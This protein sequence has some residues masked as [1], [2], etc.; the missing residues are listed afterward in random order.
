M[1]SVSTNEAQ[2]LKTELEQRGIIVEAEKWDGHKHIDLV[3]HRARLNI[4]VDGN[5][6]YENQ[7]Q[8]IADLKRAHYSSR[9]GY[10]TFHIPN[11]FIRNDEH[12]KRVADALAAAVKIRAHDLGHRLPYSHYARN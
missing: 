3:I 4:E 6:H 10:D 8:I 5:H 9:G 12:L 11:E 1:V 2:A 7:A